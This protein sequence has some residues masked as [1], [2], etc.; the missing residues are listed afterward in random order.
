MVSE[1]VGSGG[2][3]TI[4]H[5][6]VI[7]RESEAVECWNKRFLLVRSGELTYEKLSLADRVLVPHTRHFVAVQSE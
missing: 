3:P 6:F 7:E 1:S 5:A 2:C 4:E